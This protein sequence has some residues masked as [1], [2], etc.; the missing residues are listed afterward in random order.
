MLMAEQLKTLRDRAYHWWEWAAGIRGASEQ[1]ASGLNTTDLFYLLDTS[2][3]V[4]Y[5]RPTS[6]LLTQYPTRLDLSLNLLFAPDHPVYMS[7]PHAKEIQ[8]IARGWQEYMDTAISELRIVRERLDPDRLRAI[9]K[10]LHD[11]QE[12]GI[13]SQAAELL[14]LLRENYRW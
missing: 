12:A 9:N 4:E 5:A 13:R 6:L 2:E 7:G 11:I 1:K 14:N 10:D 3:I 8:G